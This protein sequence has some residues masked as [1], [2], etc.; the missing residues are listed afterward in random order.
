M[1]ENSKPD[2]PPKRAE[3]EAVFQKL[4]T[5]RL[6]PEEAAEWAGQW[7]IHECAEVEDE[8]VWDALS[9]LVLADGKAAKDEYLYG[10]NDFKAWL[11]EFRRSKT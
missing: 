6:T 9:T 2:R 11:E 5:K 8:A 10:E 1:S 4:I 3:V 7:A